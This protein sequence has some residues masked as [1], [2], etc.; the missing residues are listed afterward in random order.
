MPR[1]QQQMGPQVVL[2]PCVLSP[3]AGSGGTVSGS[4]VTGVVSQAPTRAA[5]RG[6]Q[7]VLGLFTST[8]HRCL[9]SH[10]G[11]DCLALRLL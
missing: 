6:Q 8:T 10:T 11:H 7:P 5:V 1:G 4:T 9:P 3:P 2:G